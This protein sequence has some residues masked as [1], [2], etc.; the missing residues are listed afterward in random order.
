MVRTLVGAI[1]GKKSAE[2]QVKID[3]CVAMFNP[4]INAIAAGTELWGEV[5]GHPVLVSL[6]IMSMLYKTQTFCPAPSEL[7]KAIRLAR[8]Q[9]QYQL[10]CMEKALD[11]LQRAEEILFDHA[12]EEWAALYIAR[13]STGGAGFVG[14]RFHDE[15][16]AEWCAAL[17]EIDNRRCD[18]IIREAIGKNGDA[19]A[20]RD[21]KEGDK[22]PRGVTPQLIPSELAERL[23]GLTECRYFLTPS[24]IAIV[25]DNKVVEV[26]EERI[27]S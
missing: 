20:S 9:L 24:Q 19:T 12:R 21:V 17:E 5:P 15:R 6:G 7:A 3:A 11:R 10:D 25:D 2:D 27:E 26:I 14:D 23:P 13:Q 4:T 18:A 8:R 16:H 22:V 1:A